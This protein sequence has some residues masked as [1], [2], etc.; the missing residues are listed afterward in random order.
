VGAQ[1]RLIV[2]RLRA[3]GE[4]AGVETPALA[5]LTGALPSPPGVARSV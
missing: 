3:Q 4:A 2:A 1:T 5:Q